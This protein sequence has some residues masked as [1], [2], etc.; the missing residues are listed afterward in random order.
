M[1]S[2]ALDTHMPILKSFR[3]GPEPVKP[4]LYSQV[5]IRDPGL[6]SSTQCQAPVSKED[7]DERNLQSDNLAGRQPPEESDKRHGLAF[8]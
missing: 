6:C 8:L 1:V 5:W 3:F 7:L 4:V 2:C